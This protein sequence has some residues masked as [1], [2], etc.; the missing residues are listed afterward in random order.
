MLSPLQIAIL[1]NLVTFKQLTIPQLARLNESKS[2]QTI[3]RALIKLLKRRKPLINRIEFKKVSH[4][5]KLS[6]VHSLTRS[7][8]K[9][10]GAQTDRN[11]NERVFTPQNP[12]LT[13]DYFHRVTTIDFHISTYV[14][15]RQENFELVSCDHYFVVEKIL[16]SFQ[17]INKISLGVGNSI[18]PD[19]VV[20]IAKKGRERLIFFEL[21]NGNAKSR[22]KDQIK[23][24]ALCL[25]GLYSHNKYNIEKARYY[26]ILL[27]FEEKAVMTAVIKDIS[28]EIWYS[29]ISRFFLCKTL[30]KMN[31]SFL[32]GWVSLEGIEAR[33]E[34]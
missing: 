25:A 12:R 20:M 2:E 3:R 15:S 31:D 24:H 13:D 26:Y 11:I 18:I 23:Q 14:R 16:N 10:L 32:D 6:Y 34:I 19:L 29:E 4:F 8:V 9:V 7:G 5:G 30:D 33:I 21:H 28:T 22:I 17:P 27:V 1:E